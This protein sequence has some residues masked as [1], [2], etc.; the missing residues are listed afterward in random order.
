MSQATTTRGSTDQERA[1]LRLLTRQIPN[2]D[3]ATAEIALRAAELELPKPTTHIIS[4]IHGDDIK[5]RHVINNASGMLRP[6]VEQHF[7]GR[8]AGRSLQNFLALLH[9]PRETLERLSD[10]Q[11]TTAAARTT[12][13]QFL[14]LGRV[15]LQRHAL[16]HVQ[17]LLPQDYRPLLI[18]LLRA[19]TEDR[20]N[21]YLEATLANLQQRSQ[22]VELIRIIVRLVRNLA[23]DEL[24]IGGDCWDRGKRGDRVVGYLMQQPNVSFIWGNHDVAWLGACLGHE[25]LIAHVLR[26]SKKDTA[27]R[28]SP[29][30]I[31]FA[32]SMPTIR[33]G[34]TSPRAR[35]C[36]R[37]S[38]WP[39]CRRPLRSCCSSLKANS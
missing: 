37:R 28:C 16:Q 18:E 19:S 17:R 24:I 35:G 12:V 25:A 1:A 13:A 26:I 30:R 5:L 2:P 22:L 31:W 11:L 23:V 3:A 14:E 38:S 4:D 7:A 20:A 9:Y 32:R 10:A 27:S 21:A 39:G 6:L 36:D 33:P 8:L 15:L 34:V 29:W